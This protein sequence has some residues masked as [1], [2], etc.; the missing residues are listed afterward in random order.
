MSRFGLRKRLKSR[1]GIGRPDRS[2]VSYK[3]T[4]ELPDGPEQVVEAEERYRVLMAGQAL[5]APIS[6]VPRAARP[7]PAAAA[8]AAGAAR[9]ST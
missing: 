2:I 6:T 5:P 1:L 9:S 8:A 7:C 4:Y 3:I